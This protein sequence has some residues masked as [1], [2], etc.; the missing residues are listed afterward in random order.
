MKRKK[1][2]L[3]FKLA[4]FSF[5]VYSLYTLLTLQ[6]QINDR[7]QQVL[8]LQNEINHQ[9]VINEQLNDMNEDE[10][11]NKYIE[12]TARERLGLAMPEDKIYINPDAR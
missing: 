12:K 8:D 1:S 7:K 2:G 4:V 6:F 3:F 10:N 11:R 9:K 5:A